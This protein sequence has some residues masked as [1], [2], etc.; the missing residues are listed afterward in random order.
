MEVVVNPQE[1][2]AH[3]L[4]LEKIIAAVEQNNA[5]VG[6]GYIERNQEQYI[7]RGEALVEDVRD[8]EEVVVDTGERGSPIFLKQIAEIR[9]GGML[10]IGGATANGEGETV[11]GM[12][13]MLAGENAQQVVR[14]VKQKLEEIQMSLPD[15]VLKYIPTMTGPNSSRGCFKRSP[16]IS[17]KGDCSWLPYCFFSWEASGEAFW[18]L[19]PFLSP[20]SS[21]LEG[22][23][24]LAF[25]GI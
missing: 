1:L 5:N 3:Q 2:I 24:S 25:Q 4:T 14:R 11:I 7:I 16:L 12:V 9:E 22:C 6:S 15:G 10:R 8:L 20:C 17:S 19:S 21:P 18:W 23:I 13:Q